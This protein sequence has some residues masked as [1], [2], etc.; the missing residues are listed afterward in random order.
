MSKDA[1]VSM[2]ILGKRKPATGWVAV[3]RLQKLAI[4]LRG[5]RS[6]IPRGVYRFHTFEEAQQW[7]LTMMTRPPKR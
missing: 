1:P 3:D 2:K 5:S 6:F 4:Q 7:S